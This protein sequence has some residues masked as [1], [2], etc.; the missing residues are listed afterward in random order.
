MPA[1]ILPV[2]R[3]WR[4]RSTRNTRTNDAN[5]GAKWRGTAVVVLGFAGG[6]MKDLTG[7]EGKTIG[8]RNRLLKE[9]FGS[10]EKAGSKPGSPTPAAGTPPP[11]L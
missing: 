9:K 10:M 8:E 5:T 4:L 2:P 3:N 7:G 11:T 1:R 6:G